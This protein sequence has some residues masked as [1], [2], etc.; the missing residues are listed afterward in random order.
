MVPNDR[1]DPQQEEEQTPAPA[2]DQQNRLTL[3]QEAM[4]PAVDTDP[5][6]V[7]VMSVRPAPPSVSMVSGHMASQ[8]QDR[9]GKIGQGDLVVSFNYRSGHFGP[10]YARSEDEVRAI[11]AL[12]ESKVEEREYRDQHGGRRS[13]GVYASAAATRARSVLPPDVVSYLDRAFTKRGMKE[14]IVGRKRR[15]YPQ[16]SRIIR[17]DP[18][19]GQFMYPNGE[20]VLSHINVKAEIIDAPTVSS[21]SDSAVQVVTEPETLESVAMQLDAEEIIGNTVSSTSNIGDL[22]E[23]D[24]YRPSSKVAKISTSLFGGKR[25]KQLAALDEK[26]EQSRSSLRKSAPKS[27]QVFSTPKIS[28]QYG[29]A[30]KPSE[31]EQLANQIIDSILSQSS[32]KKEATSSSQQPSQSNHSINTRRKSSTLG[33]NR[34]AKSLT[35]STYF[36]PES[37]F[38]LP[39]AS[40]E[41]YVRPDK[42]GK[43]EEQIRK[44]LEKKRKKEEKQR[45]RQLK[46]KMIS[47]G[48]QYRGMGQDSDAP[49]KSSVSKRFTKAQPIDGRKMILKESGQ[50]VDVAPTLPPPLPPPSSLPV[51]SS[52]KQSSQLTQGERELMEQL[53]S[54]GDLFDTEPSQP[55]PAQQFVPPPAPTFMQNDLDL[56]GFNSY[57]ANDETTLQPDF[58][59][60]DD[61]F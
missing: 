24:T 28:K 3:K 4:T 41:V 60:L 32:K 6:S 16:R 47:S 56:D 18:I 51:P 14:N 45:K 11:V 12:T 40:Q 26:Q 20:V 61:M 36:N 59:A 52:S 25:R 9:H 49:N 19:T 10:I 35:P 5:S 37:L 34:A 2:T 21:S 46:K 31:D 1:G 50:V 27:A 7:N 17:K 33:E 30:R 23:E 13:S 22:D 39:N 57:S 42:S 44:F 43:R 38:Q 29:R 55:P 8:M 48:S 15:N 53:V 58:S 54:L